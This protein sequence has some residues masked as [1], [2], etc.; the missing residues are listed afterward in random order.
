[1][2]ADPSPGVDP[3]LAAFERERGRLRGLAY[4][5]LG[6]H[7][8]ADDVVQDAWLRWANV[9]DDVDSARAYLSR[10][11]A[12]LCL[13]RMKSAQARRE[14]YVGPWLPEPEVE[15]VEDGP[16]A[17]HE[18]AEAVTLAFLMTLQRLSPLE[19][20]A[21]LLHDVFELEFAEI[22]V[23]LER[24]PAAC[25]QLA[26]RARAQLQ[27]ARPRQP[28]SPQRAYALMDAFTEAALR[29]DLQRLTQMLTEDA[30]FLSDGGGVVAAARKPVLG[31]A[32]V[33]KAYSGFLRK[34][35]H[36]LIAAAQRA[37]INGLPGWVLRLADGSAL[38]TVAFEFDADTRIAA[39]YVVRNPDKLRH[40]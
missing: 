9:R 36:P 17:V 14:V 15:F 35:R 18:R 13:D 22:A 3:R 34:H 39:I 37:R 24:T 40:L 8:E 27:A 11:V 4:R 1:M 5:M 7:A 20:A 29:G 23:S 6:S 31:A 32:R 25:R 30:C 26:T 2:N 12:H 28:V 33:G 38:Q 16:D 19:R 21:F 10:T